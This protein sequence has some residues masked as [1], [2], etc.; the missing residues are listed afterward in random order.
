MKGNR[1]IPWGARE[2]GEPAGRGISVFVI[3]SGVNPSH[4]HV[5]EV[6]G[7]ARVFREPGGEIRC[8]EGDFQDN[9]GH[10]T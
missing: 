9:L 5:K 10:G 7:G 2:N 1:F 6:S 8:E 4:S 3:D